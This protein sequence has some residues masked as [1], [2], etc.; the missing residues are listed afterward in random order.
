MA[1]DVPLPPDLLLCCFAALLFSLMCGI[2]G[3]LRVHPPRQ[4][5]PPPE[6][7]I[8]ESWLDILDESVKHRGP[9][10]HGR[11]R[12][13][14]LRPDGSTVDIA[15]VHRRL[16]IIDHA[17]GHQP[18]VL[19][20]RRASDTATQDSG[21]RTQDPPAIIPAGADPAPYRRTLEHALKPCP[22]CTALRRG[23][24]AVVFNGCI[25]N[26]RELRKELQSAGHVFSTDHSDT[27]ALV[28]GWGEWGDGLVTR[29]DGMFATG[30]WD[31]RRAALELARDLFG[32]KPLYFIRL[33]RGAVAFSS[34]LAAL[35]KLE[36]AAGAASAPLR[37]NLANWIRLG[38]HDRLPLPASEVP[39]GG[40]VLF[41]PFESVRTYGHRVLCSGDAINNPDA[42]LPDRVA[43]ALRDAVNARL[44]ADVTVGCFLSGGVD[45]SLIAAFARDAVSDLR[46]YSVRM[47]DPKYDESGFA[48]MV[49]EKLGTRH[50]TLDCRPTPG[51][52]LPQLVRQLGL[53][54]G[55]SSLLPTHWVSRA[56][57]DHTK[58][59]LAGD[60]G[61]ELFAGYERH[62]AVGPGARAAAV[63]TMIPSRLL[64]RRNPKSKQ[65]KLARLIETARA[66]DVYEL[67][68]VFQWADIRLLLPHLNRGDL[69]GQPLR[70]PPESDMAQG[71]DALL[72]V[73]RY[74]YLPQDLLRKSDSA[75]MAVALEVRSPM[76]ARQVGAL[77][78]SLSPRQ[79][80]PRGQRKGL[81]RAVARKYFPPE[82]VDRPKQG[83]AIPI[84]EWFRTDYGGMRQLLLDHL[85]GPE[86]FGP[87]HLGINATINMGFVK[88]MLREHDDAG[89]KSLW[90]WKGRDHSQ[91]LYMLLVLSIWA[92]WLGS[93]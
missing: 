30:A 5:P 29:A 31:S 55:D 64:A 91:R 24:I 77:A 88:K 73:D 59:A 14:A 41:D 58:V 61:D 92:K 18:M 6:V 23:T 39:S 63:L 19:R 56:T 38:F 83:F 42:P 84:G 11:F 78:F 51:E 37:S 86:P 13:R 2:A 74:E 71:L 52:D 44:E 67:L 16:S 82:I 40:S 72:H 68:A 34:T 21:P 89:V 46:T 53:P 22:R 3:I 32:E 20:A 54:F 7:A 28:H 17:G 66:N 25:Y 43:R 79:L 62:L 26:H 9:D 45:S 48:R 69:S 47:P 57:R 1:A 93:L 81:L 50:T 36:R 10:G 35:A 85:S 8:P 15:F 87:D 70:R 27:E 65:A 4:A 75:S 80:M 33:D 76:L 49:A 90:P 60:G 12:D